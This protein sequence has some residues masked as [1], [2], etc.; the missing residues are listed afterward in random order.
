MDHANMW[1]NLAAN[2]MFD[3]DGYEPKYQTADDPSK[4]HALLERF[5]EAGADPN[6]RMA[7][8]RS[9]LEE[10]VRSGLPETITL[11]VEH[12]AS[13]DLA[14]PEGGNVLDFL[15]R[16]FH[17]LPQDKFAKAVM[18]VKCGARVDIPLVT[19]GESF[20]M[21]VSK[22]HIGY[23]HNDISPYRSLVFAAV[24][25]AMDFEHIHDVLT[26]LF[27]C[28]AGDFRRTDL[29]PI[30]QVL[31]DHGAVLKDANIAAT[32]ASEFIGPHWGWLPLN[33][34]YS[35][36][37]FLECLLSMTPMRF[38]DGLLT[39]AQCL[40]DKVSVAIIV[41]RIAEEHGAELETTRDFIWALIGEQ[42]PAPAGS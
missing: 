14:T 21:G 42:A 15:L 31:M 10:A 41:E 5:I 7:N 33:P 20:L 12:G 13:I 22:L 29:V 27:N 35:E 3:A 9:L 39:R 19:T 32:A 17:Q 23:V 28:S 6:S 16:E 11:L 1:S 34:H 18:L 25:S 26:N 40:E 8:E 37:L 2:V 24:H 36:E 38:L 30:C 4:K